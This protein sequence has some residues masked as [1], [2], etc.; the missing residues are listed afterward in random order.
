MVICPVLSL[1]AEEP[2]EE[3]S[4]QEKVSPVANL[5]WVKSVTRQYSPESWQLLM[6]YEHLPSELEGSKKGGW[7]VT[8]KKSI[9]TFDHLKN[10]RTRSELLERMALNI[11]CVTGSL[12]RFDVFS[13]TRKNQLMMDWDK[14]EAFFYL[15]PI[16]S[17]YVSFP[18]ASLFPSGIL[19]GQIPDSLQT[20][21]FDAV[22]KESETSRRFGVIGLLEE[23]HSHYIL[24][25][26]YL[27]MPEAYK[28][29]E[30]SEADGFF[31]W[32]RQSQGTMSGFYEIDFFILEYLL[33]MKTHRPADYE[34][35]RT[36][37]SFADAYRAIRS[38]Y[39]NLV[40]RYLDLVDAQIQRINIS[41]TASAGFQDNVLW[42]RTTGSNSAKGARALT[43]GKTLLP[44]LK[45]DRYLAVRSDFP[46]N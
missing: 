33:Y 12:L 25:R 32:V 30:S 7:V 19:A 23:F 16:E 35:L 11:S 3:N 26:F 20:A 15:S 40:K 10:G 42:V 29:S 18:L 5:E 45:G 6:R 36:C 43:A 17:F 13:H 4:A 34:A 46:E 9:G 22:I 21:L 44:V 38:S 41:G 2:P 24:S 8:M 31:E 14:A 27:D 28:T 39:E 37:R 1:A